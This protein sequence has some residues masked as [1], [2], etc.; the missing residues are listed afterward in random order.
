M[1]NDILDRE[2]KVGDFVA[3][4]SNIYRITKV[5]TKSVQD[6]GYVSIKTVN[7][8][9]KSRPVTKYSRYMCLIP[10]EDVIAWTIKTGKQL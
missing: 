2:L 8:T 10:Q 1:A 9:E 4:Y 7:G 6:Y 3:F 5:P